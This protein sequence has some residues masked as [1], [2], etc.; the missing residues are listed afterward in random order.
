MSPFARKWDAK[1]KAKGGYY[2]A[3]A[4]LGVEG[5]AAGCGGGDQNAGFE[6]GGEVGGFFHQAAAEAGAPEVGLDEGTVEIGVAVVA[7]HD[8]DE[9]GWG[10]PVFDDDDEASGDLFGRQLDTLLHQFGL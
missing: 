6:D 3:E 4:A 1:T 9:A 8:H 10:A 7:R 2:Y 5:Y